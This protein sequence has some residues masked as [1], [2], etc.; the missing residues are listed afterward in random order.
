MAVVV[1][2][3]GRKF[4]KLTVLG[5]NRERPTRIRWNCLCECGKAT[6]VDTTSL[7][8]GRTQSCG[9]L[10]LPAVHAACFTHG[11]T[12]T[13]LHRTWGLIIQRCENPNNPSY[14]RYGGRGIRV[15]KRWRESFEAFL[16]DMGE[17]PS[18]SHTVER[19]NNN[20]NYEP[21]NCYWATRTEQA[22]NRRS[23]RLIEFDGKAMTAAEWGEVTG[24]GSWNIRQRIDRYGWPVEKALTTPIMQQ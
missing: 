4:G 12:G 8:S 9:C 19:E 14:G 13:Y 18:D 2:L 6:A 17:R 24:I 11:R 7:K 5:I 15:C 3:S 22:R 1:D 16:E 23:S 21:G 20:G 10:R